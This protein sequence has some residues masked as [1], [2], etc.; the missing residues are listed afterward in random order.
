MAALGGG[1]GGQAGFVEQV[2]TPALIALCLSGGTDSITVAWSGVAGN[3]GYSVYCGVSAED[4]LPV[5]EQVPG[6][7]YI[8]ASLG[9]GPYFIQVIAELGDRSSVASAVVCSA[10]IPAPPTGL[11]ATAQ[12]GAVAL[13]W[14]AVP[15]VSYNIYQGTEPREEG[16]APVQTGIVGGS[17]TIAGL[18]SGTAYYFTISASALVGCFSSGSS[19]EASAAPTAPPFITWDPATNQ[20]WTLSNGDLSLSA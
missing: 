5:A 6:N 18:D 8:I 12:N 1:P 3:F 14:D 4:L 13:T 10:A 16:S 19:S 11:V 20:N 15:G 2:A 17:T 7:A 9:N